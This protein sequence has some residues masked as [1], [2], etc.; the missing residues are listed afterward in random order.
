MS[1]VTRSKVRGLALVLAKENRQSEPGITRIL[2]FPDDREVRLVEVEDGLPASS[3]EQVEPFY[4]GASPADL[5][6]LPSGIALIRPDEVGKLRLP[7]G[8]GDWAD[9]EELELDVLEV[10]E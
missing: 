10:S 7:D 9:A 2:W 4:F 5:F 1:R 3:G 8:W 6:P